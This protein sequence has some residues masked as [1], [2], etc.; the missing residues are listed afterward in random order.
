MPYYSLSALPVTIHAGRIRYEAGWSNARRGVRQSALYYVFSGKLRFTVAGKSTLLTAGTA[1]LLTVGLPYS[2]SAEEDCDYCYFHFTMEECTDPAD[3]DIHFEKPKRMRLPARADALFLPV[4]E[5]I[6]APREQTEHLAV[7]ALRHVPCALRFDK[8]R[9]DLTLLRLLLL[10]AES[11][12]EEMQDGDARRSRATYLALRDYVDA[13]YTKPLSLSS[14]SAESC[15]SPQ[16]AARVFRRHAGCSITAYIRSVRLD[17]AQE[18]LRYTHLSVSEVAFAVGFSSPYYFCRLFSDALG[19][20][21]SVFR[22][23]AREEA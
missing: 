2:V 1:F 13:N 18:L 4:A 12:S 16:Y 3:P 14:V 20:P 15:I 6:R 19:V 22:S 5:P 23:R 17:R 21:P 9:L 8:A 11:A 10:L 7:S